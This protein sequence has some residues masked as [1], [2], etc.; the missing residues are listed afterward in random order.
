MALTIVLVRRDIPEMDKYAQ[1][2]EISLLSIDITFKYIVNNA[3]VTQLS[4]ITCSFFQISMS[5][6]MAAMFAM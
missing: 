2:H 1:V 5:A 4:E 3:L 6:G